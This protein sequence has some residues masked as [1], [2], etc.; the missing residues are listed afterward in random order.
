M[1]VLA[2]RRIYPGVVRC[3]GHVDTSSTWPRHLTI[4][5]TSSAYPCGRL[6]SATAGGDEEDVRCASTPTCMK[7]I[8]AAICRP[9][10][11]AVCSVNRDGAILLHRHTPPPELF[12]N[13]MAPYRQELVAAVGWLSTWYGLADLCAPGGITCG[14][15]HARYLKAVPG[16]KAKQAR[17]GAQKIAV[18]LRGG[19]S[20]QP[21]AYPATRRA[22]RDLR[23]R[24]LH[25]VRP[26]AERL[27]PSRQTNSQGHGPALGL[28]RKSKAQRAGGALRLS[29]PAAQQNIGGDPAFIG[30]D[31]RLI[32]DLEARR[33]TAAQQH[34]PR[35]RTPA[36]GAGHGP[37]L[38]PSGALR[39][40]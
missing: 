25:R 21:Y 26:R 31:D 4:I 18:L 20:P 7:H 32:R 23:R 36:V 2:M 27:T 35:P 15:G 13:A 30:S 34:A 11:W 5:E 12:P 8:A 37:D 14:L 3:L 17:L 22:T 28:P 38:Q 39:P 6:A 24:R 40:P 29:D 33:M 16:G 9:R 19:L 1:L 10:R